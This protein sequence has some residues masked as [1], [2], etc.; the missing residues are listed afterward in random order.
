MA[1]DTYDNLKIAVLGQTHRK[2]LN[3]KFDDFL[4]ITEVEIRSNSE[5]ALKLNLNEKISTAAADISTRFLALP[6]GFQSSRKF[7]I[8]I[9]DSIRG[10]KFRTPDQLFIRDGTGTPCF[11]TVRNNKIEFDIVPDIAYV[12]T[13]T[14]QSDLTALSPANQTNNILTKYPTVYLYGCL[15]QAFIHTRNTE[16]SIIYDGLFD[17]AIASANMAEHDIKYSN[18]PQETVAWAP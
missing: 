3:E 1:Y 9:D 18:Q 13:I 14:Y 6:A 16:Q 15:K 4:D 10:L 7:T 11:F 8:T 12:T 2:D 17:E 5:G